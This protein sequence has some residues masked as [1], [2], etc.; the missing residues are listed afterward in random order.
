MPDNPLDGEEVDEKS[1]SILFASDPDEL[2]DDDLDT[3]V[4][5]LEEGYKRWRS[6]QHKPKLQKGGKKR[7]RASGGVKAEDLGINLD[8][9][10]IEL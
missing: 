6:E 5:G 8:D 7:T 4:A 9:I 3:I 10:E 1:L 2:S